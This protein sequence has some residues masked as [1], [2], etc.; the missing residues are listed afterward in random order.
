MARDLS[1]LFKETL[2]RAERARK[3]KRIYERASHEAYCRGL[4]T[5]VRRYDSTLASDW[6]RQYQEY[7]DRG[8]ADSQ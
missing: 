3:G 7:V 4:I 1:E 5:G 2:A 6:D 8:K